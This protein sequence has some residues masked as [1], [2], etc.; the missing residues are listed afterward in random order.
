MARYEAKPTAMARKEMTPATII[1]SFDVSFS[2]IFASCYKYRANKA[3]CQGGN[4][5]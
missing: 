4:Y 1:F 2:V 3:P 5:G